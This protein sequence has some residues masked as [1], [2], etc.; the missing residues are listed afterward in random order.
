MKKNLISVAAGV[1]LD[2]WYNREG[3]MW[4]GRY[5]DHLDN[6]IGDAWYDS[7]RDYILIFR[8]NVKKV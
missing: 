1:F 6:Q 7:S 8:P 5:V 2:V 3:R 4:W